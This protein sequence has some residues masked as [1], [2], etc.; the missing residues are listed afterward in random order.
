MAAGAIMAVTFTCMGFA[1]AYSG[2]TGTQADPYQIARAEDWVALALTA[3]D[4]DK[5]FILFGDID[6]MGSALPA[7]GNSLSSPFTGVLDGGGHVL[8]NAHITLPLVTFAGLFGCL[9]A[10]GE[11]RNLGVESISVWGG[12]TVGGLLGFNKGG[13]VTSCYVTGTVT[14][15]F[16]GGLIGTNADGGAVTSCRASVTVTGDEQAGGLVGR[17]DGEIAACSASGAVSGDWPVGGLAG[18]NEG[19]ITACYATGAVTGLQL[20][21]GLVGNNF[22]GA[23]T[24]CYATGLVSGSV[25]FGGLVGYNGYHGQTIRTYG[26]VSGSFWDR[27]SSGQG[28]S[29]G[30]GRGLMT[31]QMHTVLNYQ[32]AGWHDYPWVMAE[33]F[34]PRLAWEGTG[35]PAIPQPVPVP[36]TGN[37]TEANPIQIV[38]AT[39]FALLNCYTSV[40]DK[41]I[42]LMADID[43]SG[44]LLNPIG[45]LGHFSGVFDG[46][47]HVIKNG[48]VIQPEREAVGLFSYVGE[49]GVLRNIGMDVLQ[50]EGDRY[51]GCLAGFNH[52]VL[53]SCHSN[54]AV[55]GNGYLGGLVGLN[56]GGM[57]SC[58]ATGSVTGGAESYA[59][60]GLAGANEG[61]SLD[62]CRASS[63][64]DGND[65]VG[66]LLGHNGWEICE[67]WG[68]WG[69]GSVTGCYATGTVVGNKRTGGLVGLNWGHITSCCAS[70]TIQAADSVHCGGLVGYNGNGGSITWCYAR[71]GVSGNENVGGLAGYTAEGSPIT[72]CYAASPVSGNRNAGGL[73]GYATG[74]AENSYWD[75][76]VSG[77]ETSAG[78]EARSTEEMAFPHAANTYEG[79]DFASVWAADTDSSV[80]DGY[81]YLI[82][83]APTLFLPAI[84]VYH[85]EDKCMIPECYT[86]S[87]CSF[88]AEVL[89]RQW[90]INGVSRTGETEISECFEYSDTYTITLSL[91]TDGGVYVASEEIFVEVF[92]SWGNYN[93]YFEVDSHSGP[94]PL[95]VQFTDLSSVEG[96]CIEVHWEWNFDD[97]YSCGD[98]EGSSFTHTFPTPGTYHVCLHTECYEP[99]C[100]EKED[101]PNYRDWCETITVLE[102]EGE[103]SEGENPAPHDADKD[104]DFRIVMG[105]AVAYLTGWQQGSNPMAYAI[106]AA[107]LWQN[108]EHYV[109]DSEQAPPMCWVLAP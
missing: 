82:G 58:R 27:E 45:D 33:G 1:A 98:C 63:T 64:V 104:G 93:A 23:I 9:D 36:W 66:G 76:T 53:K 19:S 103:P 17:N 55:T 60:G 42:R 92:P 39:E 107:Y 75:S 49:N 8:R 14:G 59:I 12:G 47:G 2:G 37:G 67:E 102:S 13:K 69:E 101:S 54:G 72:S 71:G 21:G 18:S 44:I 78:G 95:T 87:D 4:Q 105:E 83:N 100:G 30:G 80:N 28:N 108:G 90:A 5:N 40:L 68:C 84:C 79:W 89:S 10:G 62:S 97:G 48:Q 15:F 29:F 51:V 43:L 24:S 96:E 52:G 26:I 70:G 50:A 56:W 46:G 35:E 88:G 25:N 6:F 3:A 57:K 94:A 7:V 91:V 32:N 38:T 11:I 41:H 86:F 77:Q 34:L 61:G 73:V 106:R 22:L 85:H 65:R 31:A 74:P 20:V 81:P 109:Y 16:T 99:E